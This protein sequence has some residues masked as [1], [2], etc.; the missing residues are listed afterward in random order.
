MLERLRQ[1]YQN[2]ARTIN[3]SNPWS[4]YVDIAEELVPFSVNKAGWAE[5]QR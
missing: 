5:K 4:R 2:W 1:Q 3:R